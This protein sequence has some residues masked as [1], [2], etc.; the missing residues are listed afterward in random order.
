MSN[1]IFNPYKQ[2]FVSETSDDG[3]YIKYLENN[4]VICKELEI[5]DETNNICIKSNKKVLKD[6]LDLCK[7]YLEI[8]NKIAP[9]DRQTILNLLNITI[10]GKKIS[11]WIDILPSQIGNNTQT[12]AAIIAIL[13][14]IIKN[15]DSLTKENLLTSFFN[16]IYKIFGV[17]ASMFS[18]LFSIINWIVKN[19]YNVIKI[20]IIQIKYVLSHFYDCLFK[21][22]YYPVYYFKTATYYILGCFEY[23]YK[24]NFETK[25]SKMLDG[26]MQFNI[27]QIFSKKELYEVKFIKE[28]HDIFDTIP[29]YKFYSKQG[30]LTPLFE[31]EKFTD[32]KVEYLN[33]IVKKQL[34]IV[35]KMIDFNFITVL[36]KDEL[37]LLQS[38]EIVSKDGKLFNLYKIGLQH[39]TNPSKQIKGLM[40]F[41]GSY[42]IVYNE[43]NK[44]DVEYVKSINATAYFKPYYKNQYKD[45]E[46][47]FSKKYKILQQE[48]K[49]FDKLIEN[50]ELYILKK[51][52]YDKHIK[53]IVQ[54]IDKYN[55]KARQIFTEM[56][57]AT[58][59]RLDKLKEE[60]KILKKETLKLLKEKYKITQNYKKQQFFINQTT[61]NIISEERK[62]LLDWKLVRN[63]LKRNIDDIE[64]VINNSIYFKDYNQKKNSF[65]ENI[66]NFYNTINFN[67]KS[68]EERYNKIILNE[69]KFHNIPNTVI[70][71]VIKN[72][73]SFLNNTVDNLEQNSSKIKMIEPLDLKSNNFLSY[74]SVNEKNKQQSSNSSPEKEQRLLE[75][76]DLIETD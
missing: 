25:T 46:K 37:K 65:I 10:F 20:P 73:E 40:Y 55:K 74:S 58:G 14:W 41:R 26:L 39:L 64:K 1:L 45:I 35:E 30:L 70:I 29:N 59:E 42:S 28:S 51:E 22:H 3:K 57:K 71:P 63:A 24:N 17:N 16:S 53:N 32:K 12:K 43:N 9:I 18:Y 50:Q 62:D 6:K 5:F 38:K 19:Q 11:Q 66:I 56:K 48:Y 49:H 60:Y 36:T 67:V 44:G 54:I 21:Y 7:N 33:R 75:V 69:R 68:F 52:S 34:P 8:K 15:V 47:E 76:F 72:T 23:V 31:N 13:I 27:K 61:L 2:I 4:C